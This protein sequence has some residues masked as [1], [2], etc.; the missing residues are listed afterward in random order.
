MLGLIESSSR[1]TRWKVMTGFGLCKSC[2]AS[3][4]WFSKLLIDWFYLL[5]TIISFEGF[6]IKFSISESVWVDTDTKEV[7]FCLYN[8]D[9]LSCWLQYLLLWS[10]L[11]RF[12]LEGK[13]S[14]S[15]EKVLIFGFILSVKFSP[16]IER[17]DR[18][19][20]VFFGDIPS[21]LS[22]YFGE[23]EGIRLFL[24]V[25]ASAISYA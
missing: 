1:L 11:R 6:L 19:L 16:A 25:E 3:L 18:D 5:L 20:L 2:I 9:F 13:T 8:Y 10:D 4:I 14:W 24:T 15:A 22:F 17:N 21:R 23:I 12:S 7:F